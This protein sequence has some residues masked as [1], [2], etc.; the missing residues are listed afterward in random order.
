MSFTFNL[1]VH[2]LNLFKTSKLLIIYRWNDFFNRK[3][4]SWYLMTKMDIAKKIPKLA[5]S[6][7]KLLA[8]I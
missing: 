4:I 7:T 1:K 6:S 3:I 2:G 5:V 8:N